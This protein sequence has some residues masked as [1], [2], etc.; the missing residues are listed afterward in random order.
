MA[1]QI[2]EQKAFQGIGLTAYGRRECGQHRAS[3]HLVRTIRFLS[4]D[5][6]QRILGQVYDPG[7]DHGAYVFGYPTPLFKAWIFALDQIGSASC[8][9]RVST[10]VWISGVAGTLKK[11]T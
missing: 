10:S 11:K 8:R 9:E 7:I 6:S 5:I 1:V 4:T 3:A 2:F